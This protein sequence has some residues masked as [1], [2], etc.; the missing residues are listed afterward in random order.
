[1]SGHTHETT[2]ETI[3]ED[4]REDVDK[5]MS[6]ERQDAPAPT[7]EALVLQLMQRLMEGQMNQQQKNAALTTA[8]AATQHGGNSGQKE[9]LP[10]LSV[11]GGNSVTVQFQKHPQLLR[12][13]FRPTITRVAISTLPLP[14]RFRRTFSE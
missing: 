1:M 3:R 2:S 5:T 6:Q 4:A 8:L 13:Q 10:K 12:S 14:L 9:R 7:M 11:F